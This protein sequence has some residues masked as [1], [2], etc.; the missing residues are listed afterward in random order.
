MHLEILVVIFPSLIM[1]VREALRKLLRTGE[2]LGDT[3]M[4]KPSMSPKL[5]TKLCS[6][7]EVYG[8]H[9]RCDNGSLASMVSYDCDV[10]SILSA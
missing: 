6:K 4:K 7:M 3:Y 1:W 5:V 2:I 10:A 8:N 9:F